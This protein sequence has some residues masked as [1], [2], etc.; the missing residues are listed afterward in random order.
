MSFFR[1]TGDCFATLAM[2]YLSL[3]SRFLVRTAVPGEP[4]FQN[5]FQKALPCCINQLCGTQYLIFSIRIAKS[6]FFNQIHR[7]FKHVFQ[8]DLYF[9]HF[10]Y[11]DLGFGIK[12]HQHIDITIG[13]KVLAQNRAKHGELVNTPAFAEFSDFLTW[14]TK[15]VPAHG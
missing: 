5:V 7:V 10:K 14:K 12:A 3:R 13:A 11:P 15:L 2:T 1:I 8:F 9:G 4:F 6:L